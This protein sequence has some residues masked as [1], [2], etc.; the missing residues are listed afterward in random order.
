MRKF[1]TFFLISYKVGTY[2]NFFKNI[3][4]C[5]FEIDLKPKNRTILI[6]DRIFQHF[7]LRELETK[8]L[9]LPLAHLFFL[10]YNTTLKLTYLL[11]PPYQRH[12]QRSNY[13]Y[14]PINNHVKIR[15]TETKVTNGRERVE[16]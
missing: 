2:F 15:F 13:E 1:P 3:S 7:F 8:I 4:I 11:R 10:Q 9:K 14:L 12:R 6:A 5:R 16:N